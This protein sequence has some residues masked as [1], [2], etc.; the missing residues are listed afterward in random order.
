[1][2]QKQAAQVRDPPYITGLSYNQKP[3]QNLR[4]IV[5]SDT[6]VGLAKASPR[7]PSFPQWLPD[8]TF[9]QGP[10]LQFTLRWTGDASSR[11]TAPVA[12]PLA[13]RNSDCSSGAAES[14]P[15]NVKPLQSVGKTHTGTRTSAS[16]I[17]GMRCI[18]NACK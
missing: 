17:T 13:T 10:T 4:V 14:R 7:S 16:H 1:M 5:F 3:S 9:S 8:L 6:Q 12:K 18:R 15:S 11:S 2:P